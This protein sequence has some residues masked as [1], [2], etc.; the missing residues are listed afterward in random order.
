MGSG[1]TRLM[2]ITPGLEATFEFLA[3]YPRAARLRQEISPP[4]RA[5]PYKAHLIVYDIENDD[6]IVILRI[7]HSREDWMIGPE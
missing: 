7:R 5:L 3:D 2:P 6:V 4:V 1:L